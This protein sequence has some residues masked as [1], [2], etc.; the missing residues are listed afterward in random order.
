MEI[1]FHLNR[2]LVL[3]QKD[4]TKRNDLVH[5]TLLVSIFRRKKNFVQG[6]CKYRKEEKN[7]TIYGSE[8]K[9]DENIHF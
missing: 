6:K 9:F 3:K 5:V 2:L 7:K 4:R 8:S 1:W